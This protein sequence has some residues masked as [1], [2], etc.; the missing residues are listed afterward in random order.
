M[1]DD[2]V[3]LVIAVCTL[4]E[5]ICDMQLVD[6][7]HV[8]MAPGHDKYLILLMKRKSAPKMLHI[9]CSAHTPTS[10]QLV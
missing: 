1:N 4:L 9:R 3:W 5:D 8:W 2:A 10:R 7:H 6:W